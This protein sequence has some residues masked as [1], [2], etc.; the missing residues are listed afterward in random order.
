MKTAIFSLLALGGA[1]AFAPS[2]SAQRSVAPLAATTA[3]LEGMIGTDI[4]NG[5]KIVSFF[6]CG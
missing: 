6:C 1:S 5:K 2:Q 4:E 3:E